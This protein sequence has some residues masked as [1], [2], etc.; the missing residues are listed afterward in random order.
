MP[1]VP[2]GGRYLR[3]GPAPGPGPGRPAFSISFR[4]DAPP[5][6]V[7]TALPVLNLDDP[8][9]VVQWLLAQGARFDYVPDRAEACE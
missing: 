7:P 9:A 8:H 2:V 5:L 4:L 1:D 3:I 6:P